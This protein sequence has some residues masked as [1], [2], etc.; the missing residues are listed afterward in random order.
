MV[1]GDYPFECADPDHDEWYQLLANG[2]S[3]EFWLRTELEK[4]RGNALSPEL[5]QLLTRMLSFDPRDRFS[6]DQIKEQF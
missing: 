1:V 3:N 5:K 6:L 4:C 2:N